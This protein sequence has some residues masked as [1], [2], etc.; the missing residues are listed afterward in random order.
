MTNTRANYLNFKY[1]KLTAE[2]VDGRQIFWEGYGDILIDFAMP[3]GGLQTV[4]LNNFWFFPNLDANLLR[5]TAL[6]EQE[7]SVI[8]EPVHGL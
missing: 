4:R 6:K 5:V 7:M 1:E 2:V 8:Y 3:Y